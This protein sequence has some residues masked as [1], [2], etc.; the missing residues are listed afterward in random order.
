MGF[1]DK[2]KG[3]TL[4]LCFETR[5]NLKVQVVHIH[6]KGIQTNKRKPEN[7]Q[8]DLHGPG[9]DGFTPSAGTQA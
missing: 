2:K 8:A 4:N 5:F 7:K 9:F 3:I 6:G 1:L